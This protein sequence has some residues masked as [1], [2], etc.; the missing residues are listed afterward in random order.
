MVSAFFKVYQ[1]LKKLKPDVITSHLFDDAV[2]CLLA[3]KLANIKT[4][5]IVKADTGFHYNYAPK[6]IKFDKL[7]NALA[8]HIIAPSNESK[9]F[10]LEKEKANPFK[11]KMI[12]HGIPS[13]I[14][15]HQTEQIKNNLIQKYQLEDKIVMGTISRLIDWKGYK[16][17]IKA[18]KLVVKKY[19]NSIFLFVGKGDQKKEL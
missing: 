10:I 17:I 6:W 15:T 12:H 2:P 13:K 3:S 1:L 5:V 9:N 11:V 7:N 18:A 19:P 4:R 8:T 14:F 16:Y